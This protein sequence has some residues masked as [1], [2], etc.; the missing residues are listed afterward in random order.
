MKGVIVAAA[1]G[2][3][4]VPPAEG[5]SVSVTAARWFANPHLSDYRVGVSRTSVGPIQVFPVGQVLAGG[6]GVTLV[7]VAVDAAV[8]LNSD[9]AVY[10]IGGAG[11]GFLDLDRSSGLGLWRSASI[12]AGAEILRLG[13][14]GSAAIEGRYQGFGGR[15][16]SGISIGLRVGARISGPESS[17]PI[18][19]A[20][21]AASAVEIAISAMGTPYQWGGSNENGFDC[22]GLI[23]YAFGQVGL[24]VPRR[25]IDQA[26]A[27]REV[28]RVEANLQAGDI[29]G[30][31]ATPGGGLS[32]VG[33]YVGNGQFIH[34]GSGGVQISRLSAADPQGRWWF[35]RWTTSRRVAE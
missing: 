35:A 27:G 34:S 28:G 16:G 18:G 15:S 20:G 11:G 2:L 21:V 5:Q 4:L 25:S 10:L 3:A 17:D 24:S 7:G 12:G 33:L 19:R 1:A 6:A 9:W 31:S 8:V 22:S 13:P 30:F 32:H 14:L 26:A 23:Q 29:L